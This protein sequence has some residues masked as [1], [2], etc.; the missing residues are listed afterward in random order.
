MFIHISCK[1]N[2]I[3][4]S[5]SRVIK[6]FYDLL[7]QPSYYITSG[8]KLKKYFNDLPHEQP[9]FMLYIKQYRLVME[10]NV[11]R[12]SSYLMNQLKNYD[13]CMLV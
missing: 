6:K 13:E 12:S 10:Q 8:H 11:S 1:F 5:Q 4:N 3:P 2:R 7:G 9:K